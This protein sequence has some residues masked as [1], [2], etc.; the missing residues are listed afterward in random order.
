MEIMKYC[1]AKL[2]KLL[3]YKNINILLLIAHQPRAKIYASAFCIFS[4]VP[5]SNQ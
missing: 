5:K 3:K 2:R 4:G 1:V